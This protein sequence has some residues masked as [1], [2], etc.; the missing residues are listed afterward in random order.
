MEKNDPNARHSGRLLVRMP[1]ELHDKLSRLAADQGV[2]LN[3]LTVA[4]LSSGAAW[5]A[6]RDGGM[7]TGQA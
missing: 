5:R 6:D 3:Q 7:A 4:L 2:S 1:H